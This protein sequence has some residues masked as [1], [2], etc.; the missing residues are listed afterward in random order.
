MK[1]VKRGIA[2]AV[3]AAMIATTFAL[4]EGQASAAGGVFP[5]TLSCSGIT[6]DGAGS[7]TPASSLGSSAQTLAVM[8]GTLAIGGE[9][10]ATIP[11][12]VRPSD[13]PFNASFAIKVILPDSLVNQTKT[14][15]KTDKFDITGAS[16]SV[17]YS[18]GASG[19]IQETVPDQTVSLA[20]TPAS[21]TNT[22]S[23]VIKPT[24]GGVITFT[25][26]PAAFG[27]AINKSVS[28]AGAN[29]TVNTLRV[30]CKNTGDIGTTN[31]QLPGAPNV[32]PGLITTMA[33]PGEDAVLN[34]A[35]NISPDDGNP[36]IPGSLRMVSQ[37]GSG[38]VQLGTLVGYHYPPDGAANTVTMEVCGASRIAKGRPGVNEVQTL[39]WNQDWNTDVNAHPLAFSL[40]VGDY[41][42][43]VMST[44]WAPDLFGNPV[45]TPVR[46]EDDFLLLNRANSHFSPPSATAVQA[47]LEKLPSVGYGNI[48]VTST[49]GGYNFEFIGAKGNQPIATKVSIGKWFTW[50]PAEAYA[51]V[52]GLIGGGGGGGE[53]A[54]TTTTVPGGTPAEPAKS[55]PE[56]Q[57]DLAA[58]KIT[59][60]QF[61]D[62]L[63]TA[64][65]P[66]LLA[67]VDLPEAVRQLPRTF[68][69]PPAFETATLGLVTIPDAPTGPLCSS[70]QVQFKQDAF[71]TFVAAVLWY[72]ALQKVQ[73]QGA[74]K[75]RACKGKLVKVRTTRKQTYY[76]NGKRHT[77]Y[78][79]GYTY[80]CRSTKR[81]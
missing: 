60:E 55:I 81:R 56:L 9:V 15:L 25:P 33:G 66:T 40:K 51:Q 62:R 18:G 79:K 65:L 32:E 72:Q 49:A 10:T 75:S 70:F 26:G 68:P 39:A 63:P 12:K 3:T 69:Q 1:F 78:V 47:E 36:I 19:T 14:L 50:M 80:V 16:F 28:V 13:P 71:K 52:Q 74:T 44:S 21:V 29:V 61:F 37:T 59:L 41:E 53:G 17:N 54:T 27:I 22:I 76:R 20:A 24:S 30:T 6:T 7:A 34:L 73:V 35:S 2:A 38:A 46:P 8:G 23:G 48:K 57:A 77:R 43:N 31:V 4:V 67:T 5:I 45:P 42:T 58:G 64:V 11:S